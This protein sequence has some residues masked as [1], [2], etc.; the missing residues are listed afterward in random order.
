[1]VKKTV[2]LLPKG[3]NNRPGY[4]MKAKGLLF[5]TTNNWA[6]GAGDEQHAEYMENQKTRVVSWHATVDKDSW[7][8]HIPFNE[9]A[10]HAGDGG[11]GH[12]NRNWIGLEIAC[13]A[14][15]PGQKLDQATY[16]N[17]VEVAAEI[18]KAEGLTEWGQLQPHNVVYGKNC[19]HTS[20]FSRDQ[21]KKDV[22][23]KL[24]NK[25]A[26][27]APATPKPAVGG[28]GG[29]Y[30]VER[31]DS[32]SKIAGKFNTTVAKLVEINKIA[33]PSLIHPGQKIK[34][35]S[36]I[37]VV[38]KGD[39]LT[40]IAEMYNTSVDYL[41]RLNDISNPGLI[42]IG[43][44]I[45][46]AGTAPAA[47]PKKP[48][49][50]AP[51]KHNIPGG[52]IRP[53]SKGQAVVDLQEVLYDHDPRFNPGKIDGSYG[54]ATQDAVKRYQMYYGVKPYDGIYGPKTEANLK[55]TYKK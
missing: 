11:S 35:P 20:L 13:E 21:F 45:K 49:V 55:K 27:P 4:S 28:D 19:P 31:G 15:A 23:A 3:H 1:M 41:V 26:A 7:T 46:L 12:Y 16:N 9:N 17:A 32:L 24:Q 5:H 14:V 25:T 52:V 37:H 30:T 40:E 54:P 36:Y 10:W 34:L 18:M 50:K 6:D 42:T 33:D 39:T 22:F 48:V 8:Q 43:Q 47:A 29:V 2:D 51:V 53:G 38:Q 44:R